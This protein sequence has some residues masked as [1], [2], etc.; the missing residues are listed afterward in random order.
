MSW[1][2]VA[3]LAY[4]LLAVAN[5]A[6][7]FFV[8]N[9]IKNS[10]AYTFVVC[11][12]GLASFLIAPWFLDWP[13]ISLT[14][15]NLINGAI[16]AIALWMLYLALKKGEASR[17][18]VVIGGSTPVFSLILSLIFFKEQF[19]L[20]QYFGIFIILAGVFLISL[21][22]KERKL[23]NRIFSFFNL[24]K[25][26]NK[27]ALIFAFGSALFYS[28]Y[29]IGTKLAYEDQAFLSS[30]IWTRLGAFI[31]V[32]IFLI[33]ESNRRAILSMFKKSESKNRGGALV[34]LN[35]VVGS[36]GFLLQNYA[37]FLGSVV[38][39]NA[40]QGVQYAFITLF[41]AV[42][43]I[44]VP[45]LLKEKFSKRI[46]L[47]KALAVILIAVGIAFLSV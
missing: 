40:L 8:D 11:L 25:D 5:L 19:S 41:S 27:K 44:T 46:I 28:L 7:K 26:G 31:F 34:L 42:L 9:I 22:P 37:I 36:A 38:L 20:N 33:K 47:Q 4:F 16:F 14:F 24:N 43:A 15:F 21:L 45:G 12:M 18:L 39:V 35:Q 30:F 2:L 13:G 23:L 6:D 29:F 1:I 32:L 10:Q 17:I 3:L